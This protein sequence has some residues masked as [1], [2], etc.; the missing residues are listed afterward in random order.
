MI[1]SKNELTY[2]FQKMIQLDVTA[3]EK[4][5]RL[6]ILNLYLADSKIFACSD[7]YFRICLINMIK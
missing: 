4:N 5:L 7:H 6:E 3:E 1:K 2:D